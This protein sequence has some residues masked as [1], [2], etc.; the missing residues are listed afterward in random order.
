MPAQTFAT[1]N[2]EQTAVEESTVA[3][4]VDGFIAVGPCVIA[5]DAEELTVAREVD[6]FIAVGPC[7]IA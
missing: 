6:G 1:K 7:V 3:R 4:E 5:K 2:I